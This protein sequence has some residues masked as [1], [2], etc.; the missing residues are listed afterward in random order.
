MQVC[1][2]DSGGV[3]D[4]KDY[5]DFFITFFLIRQYRCVFSF[6]FS[7]FEIDSLNVLFATNPSLNDH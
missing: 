5:Y 2:H 7:Y 4:K 6:M 3:E 1:L